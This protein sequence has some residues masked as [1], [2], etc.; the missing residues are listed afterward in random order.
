MCFLRYNRMQ[1]SAFPHR[2]PGRVC[3]VYN[4][5]IYFI[6]Y[7]S[8]RG[9]VSYTIHCTDVVY[10]R[11][12]WIVVSCMRLFGRDSMFAPIQSNK[13]AD[14][15]CVHIQFVCVFEKLHGKLKERVIQ[16]GYM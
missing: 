5:Y 10:I 8:S 11:Y 7:T 15:V 4:T 14:P 6:L 2:L 13:A 12:E 1:A 16:L 3:I 9:K